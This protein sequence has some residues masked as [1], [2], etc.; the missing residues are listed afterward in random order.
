MSCTICGKSLSSALDLSKIASKLRAGANLMIG[1]PDY[2]AYAAHR[3]ANH[4]DQPA[5]TREEFFRERQA[6]RFG[7]GGARAF[8]CC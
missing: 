2:D 8:R 6:A 3:A 4:P 7:E 5:M 1:Q